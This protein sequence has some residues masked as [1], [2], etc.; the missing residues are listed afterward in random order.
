MVLDWLRKDLLKDVAVIKDVGVSMRDGRG[1]EAGRRLTGV[2]FGAAG[3]F[4]AA[5]SVFANEVVAPVDDPL[6]RT[7]EPYEVSHPTWALHWD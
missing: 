7:P 5:A 4:G 3:L 2:L 1:V 6:A